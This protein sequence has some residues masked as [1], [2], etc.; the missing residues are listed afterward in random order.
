M[1]ERSDVLQTA[2]DAGMTAEIAVQ[3]K[4]ETG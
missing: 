3:A 1:G 2:I 4:W